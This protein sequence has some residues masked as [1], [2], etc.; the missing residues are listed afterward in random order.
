M[1]TN[2]EAALEILEK[3]I[4][5]EEGTGEWFTVKQD[6]I[7]LFADATHD[8]QFIHVDPEKSAK[9]SPYKTT[10]APAY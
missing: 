2:A 10:V 6:Q 4:A 5:E 1:P 8:L 3:S 7:N 9:L